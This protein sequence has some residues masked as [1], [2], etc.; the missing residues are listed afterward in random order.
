[1]EFRHA[2]K[3]KELGNSVDLPSPLLRR[4]DAYD[5]HQQFRV[6]YV[7]LATP[8]RVPSLHIQATI[9]AGKPV[10]PRSGGRGRPGRSESPRRRR[11]A[12]KKG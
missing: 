5:S 1:M 11:G 9:A 7:M 12:T 2:R 10:H 6:N 8:T 3:A 4:L